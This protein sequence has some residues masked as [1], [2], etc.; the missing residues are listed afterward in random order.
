MA[1]AINRK[2]GRLSETQVLPLLAS[3]FF[4]LTFAIKAFT[5]GPYDRGL[6][7]SAIVYTKYATAFIAC[8]LALAFAMK[9]G[10]YR[11]V[12]E[13]NELMVIVAVFTVVSAVMQLVSGTFVGGTYIELV[14][15][16]MPMVLAYCMLNALDDDQIYVCMVAV[17]I[18]SLMGYVVDMG[19]R[20]SSLSAIFQA[21]FAASESDTE[22]SGF[23]EISLML[24]F[25]FLY[26]KRSE[27]VSVVSTLFCILCFKRLAILVVSL[28]FLVSHFAPSFITVKPSSRLVTA[29]KVATLV[30]CAAWCWILLPGQERLFISLFGQTPFDFTM[31]RSMSLRYLVDS[32]F[33]S[34]GFGSANVVINGVFGVPFE[35]DLAKIAIELT[36][37][38]LALFVWLFWNL[39]KG[40][41]WAFGIVAYFMLN[42]I[43]S[44][45][46]TSNFA[47]TLAYMTLGLVNSG[48]SNKI[49][50][51]D[52]AVS[53][54]YSTKLIDGRF[55]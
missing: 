50:G 27:A 49:S 23:S 15:L 41:V 10:E 7:S 13:F 16:A 51:T 42:M 19:A 39:A 26:V 36:P 6:L 5:D 3:V 17:F 14:K 1:S 2:T 22:S 11:F 54:E 9:K 55:R 33:Q 45:S 53:R 25:Y 47:F 44:D 43:S 48:S 31:G 24:S 34:Y 8:L 12:H 40:S 37:A 18:A 38:V 29:C 46:L 52:A 21:D 28:A 30:A 35:M 20:G 4:V 32:G